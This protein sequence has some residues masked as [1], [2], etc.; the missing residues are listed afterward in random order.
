MTHR[1]WVT[2]SIEWGM[3]LIFYVFAILLAL[4]AG[5]LVMAAASVSP[6][7]AYG[8]IWQGAAGSVNSIKETLV[9]ATPLLFA[10]LSYSFAYRSGLFNIGAEGQIYIGALT[11]AM[12][13]LL[14]P[15]GTPF[16]LHLPLSL[17]CG[18]LGGA[19]WGSI[20]GLLKVGRGAS[21]IINTI[22]LN[23]IAIYL[24]SYMVTGPLKD[25]NGSMP[26]SAPLPDSSVLP[27]LLG[28]RLHYGFIIAIVVAIMMY[29][30]L[31]KTTWGYEIR[32]TGLNGQAA[33]VM[34]M[35]VRRN[36][37]M[38]MLVSGGLA[39]LGG[40]I[41]IAGVQH[42]LLQNFSPG[43][44]YEG[45]AVALLGN[46]HPLGNMLSALLFGG[47]KS[48]ANA[49][50]RATGASTSLVLVIQALMIIIVVC[51]RYWFG[52][53]KRQ[54]TNWIQHKLKGAYADPHPGKVSLSKAG[55]GKNG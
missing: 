16:L 26:Q 37:V 18:C 36:M 1:R 44:G 39:G 7:E 54:I 45:I 35:P 12:A 32:S 5:G 14:M 27:T 22:M 38:V 23:Y 9:K 24:I 34:G 17:L 6:L 10:G 51:N 15:V 46:T 53:Y 47:M 41:E 13:A 48:G 28:S 49:M 31:H 42:R 19:I 52:K 21:E 30:L 29:F 50:Q 55:G 25:P 33:K 4:V 20:A 3:E 43:Y 2:R 8:L 11:G 40:Y